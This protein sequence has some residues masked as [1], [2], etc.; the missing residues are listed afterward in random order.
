MNSKLPVSIHRYWLALKSLIEAQCSA[1]DFQFKE[2][3]ANYEGR[4]AGYICCCMVQGDLSEEDLSY[5]DRTIAP[6]RIIETSED[7][8]TK[9]TGRPEEA[10]YRGRRIKLSE[11]ISKKSIAAISQSFITTDHSKVEIINALVVEPVC[12]GRDVGSELLYWGTEYADEKGMAMRAND[13]ICS[14]YF[15]SGRI[16]GGG[17]LALNVDDYYY[18]RKPRDSLAYCMYQ[19]KYV[20]RPAR[21][22]S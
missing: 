16:S 20:V 12:R 14:L 9:N 8:M 22:R 15:E 13:Q 6:S 10:E 7:K 5:L 19:S 4:L 2:A 17:Q 21:E 18:A 1:T 3:V 11:M